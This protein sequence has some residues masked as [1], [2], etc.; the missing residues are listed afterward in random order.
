MLPLLGRLT[1]S[2]EA[3]RALLEWPG[4][5]ASVALT[6]RVAVLATAGSVAVALLLTPWVARSGWLAAASLL[7]LLAIPHAAL[8]I[9]L[10]ALV[11][12]S[13]WVARLL[14]AT[15]TGWTVPPAIVTSRDPAG[16][17]MVV[18]LMLKEVAFLLLVTRASLVRIDVQ[19]TLQVAASLGHGPARAWALAVQ[20]QLWRSLKLPVLAVLAFSLGSADV[21]LV[22]GPL[23]P[24]PLAAQVARWSVDPDPGRLLPAAAASVLLAALAGVGAGV[25]WMCARA[26]GAAVRTWAARGPAGGGDGRF[27]AAAAGVPLAVVAGG[28]LLVLPLWA[29]AASWRFPD[30]LPSGWTPELMELRLGRLADVGWTTVEVAALTTTLALALAV[31]RL[32]AGRGGSPVVLAVLLLPQPAVLFGA[33]TLLTRLGVDGTIAAVVLLH[34]VFVLPYVLLALAGP[35]R[36][37]DTRYA[38][39]AAALGAG[40]V[41]TLWRVTLPL[42]AKPVL[43]AAALGVSVS[44][45]LYLPTLFAGG[46]RV[47][48][49]AT[50]AVALASG[51]DRRLAAAAGLA[52]AALPL[53]AF[54]PAWLRRR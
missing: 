12:P 6:V 5:A 39:A 37:V 7:P 46:G 15:L 27:A 52:A 51:S 38:R 2:L 13:G 11:A 50:R 47:E 9:G 32:G 31:L 54:A 44:A 26:C 43:T 53:L 45:G 4:L 29:G 18:A 17:A 25:L 49:L 34:L 10:S 36:A 1:P 21:P 40:P 41:A 42:L 20:P 14:A 16:L 19:A 33:Q 35:W 3:W 23:T 8:A 28:S 22:L 24:P 30:V 48:T